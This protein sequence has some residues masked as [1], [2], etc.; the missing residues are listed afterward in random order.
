[1]EPIRVIRSRTRPDI[2]F[3][4]KLGQYGELSITRRPN[5]RGTE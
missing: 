1:M 5:L 4:V 3:P 2:P